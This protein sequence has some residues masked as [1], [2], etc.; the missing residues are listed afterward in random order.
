MPSPLEPGELR[1][2]TVRRLTQPSNFPAATDGGLRV[3]RRPSNEPVRNFRPLDVASPNRRVKPRQDLAA[4]PRQE[5][6]GRRS[7]IPWTTATQPTCLIQ[8]QRG[9]FRTRHGNHASLL[10]PIHHV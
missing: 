8:R 1:L 4:S 10:N 7:V 9:R 3:A 5:W 2:S 6:P